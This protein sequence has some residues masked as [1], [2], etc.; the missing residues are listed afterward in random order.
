M[1]V[2]GIDGERDGLG[3]VSQGSFVLRFPR[4]RKLPSSP[5]SFASV[6]VSVLR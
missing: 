1:A 2:C 3:F 6:V 5:R 4:R